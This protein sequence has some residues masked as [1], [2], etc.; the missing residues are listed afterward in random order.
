[1]RRVEVQTGIHPFVRSQERCLKRKAIDKLE[2][3]P[4]NDTSRGFFTLLYCKRTVFK[5]KHIDV[6]IKKLWEDLLFVSFLRLS[7]IVAEHKDIAT[8]G[9]TMKIA[10][11]EDVATLQC[12]LHH[13]FGVI[14]DWIELA[15]CTN[16]LPI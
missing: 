11:E 4:H 15:R 6:L 10:K 8:S 16:P 9:M 2:F 13:E 7:L 14:V 3:F 12:S 5:A 1:M